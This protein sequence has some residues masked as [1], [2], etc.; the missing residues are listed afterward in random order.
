[1]NLHDLLQTRERDGAPIRVG[2]IGAG[3]F[4]TM[5]LAQARTIPGIHVAAI[6]DINLDR[7]KQA[8]KLVDWPEDAVTGRSRRPHWPAARPRSFR[9]RHRCS[10]TPST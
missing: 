6:A 3:R 4:G 8:L 9:T 5:F 7:A 1:M 2:L 10:P